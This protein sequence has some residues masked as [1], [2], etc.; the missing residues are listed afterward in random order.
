MKGKSKAYRK[1]LKLIKELLENLNNVD[2][3]ISRMEELEKSLS[4]DETIELKKIHKELFT[5]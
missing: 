2:E 3:I 1:F 4:P 5:K